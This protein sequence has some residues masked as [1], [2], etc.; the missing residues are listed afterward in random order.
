MNNLVF[1]L[2]LAAGCGGILLS[3]ARA[4]SRAVFAQDGFHQPGRRTAAFGLLAAV[5]LLTVA[6]PFAGGL[7]GAQ[8]ESKDLTLLSV[9]AVH[10]ILIVFLV[11][12]YALSG[13]HSVSEFLKTK[14]PRPASDLGA[15]FLIGFAGWLM[16]IIVLLVVIGVWYV[17]R[18]N[19]TAAPA[20][21][22]SPTIVWLVSQ[23]LAIRILI[24]ISAMVV[25]EL[26]FRSFLQ[27]RVGALAATLMFTAAHGAYGQPL[28]LVG[29]LVI[30]TVLSV[31]FALYG[32]VLPCIVAH[33]VFDSIQMFV[34]I[35]LAL[36]GIPT[37]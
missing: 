11:G 14:S 4:R 35:P 16:T 19:E 15:G 37:G 1:A 27:P 33:G 13:R 29:I 34:L 24:V 31:T 36:K 26:F 32:N 17:A 30:S 9:F 10:L 25:E 6:I 5:L 3:F 18:R 28:V 20:R 21:E 8:P 12:Y 23:P 2:L 22:V 7:A